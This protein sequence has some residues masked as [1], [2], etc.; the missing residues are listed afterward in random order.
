MNKLLS[1]LQNEKHNSTKMTLFLDKLSL[2]FK[3]E[4]SLQNQIYS[5]YCTFIFN[6]SKKLYNL[7]LIDEYAKFVLGD[8]FIEQS[9]F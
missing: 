3:N 6:E 9:K 2:N 5:F 8:L 4:K 1:F 7:L